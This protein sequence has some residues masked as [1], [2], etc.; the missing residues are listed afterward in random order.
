MSK[1]LMGR[2]ALVTGSTSNIGKAIAIRFAAEGARVVVTGRDVVRG[3]AVLEA[4]HA[5]GGEAT[6][7]PHDLDG[8]VD[9]SRELAKLATRVYGSLDILVNNAGVYPPEGTLELDGQTFD[10]IVGVN[11]KAPYFLTAAVVPAMVDAGRGVVINLGSWGARTG[12]PAGSAYASTKGAMETLTRAW[13]AEFGA[14]GIRVN[15]I[16]P[17]VTFEGTNPVVEVAG[18]MMATTPIGRLVNPDS[19]AHAAVF[20]ASDDAADIHGTVLDVDGGRSSVLFAAR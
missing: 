4:V 5:D 8:S 3:Q 11:V 6:F 16:S 12:I 18:P 14:L 15:A 13:A 2:A 1:R 9:G 19:I 10:R 20:L 7:L 17:G